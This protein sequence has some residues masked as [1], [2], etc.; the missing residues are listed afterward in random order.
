MMCLCHIIYIFIIRLKHK[1]RQ[2]Y[3]NTLLTLLTLFLLYFFFVKGTDI[4]T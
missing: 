1:K 2:Y 4:I 3:V